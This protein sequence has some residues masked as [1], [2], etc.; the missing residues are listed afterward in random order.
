MVAVAVV[1]IVIILVSWCG[2]SL[3]SWF[4]VLVVGRRRG[5]SS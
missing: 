3:R 1:D 2:S 4:V 5:W